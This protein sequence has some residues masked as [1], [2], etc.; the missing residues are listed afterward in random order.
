[1]GEEQSAVEQPHEARYVNYFNVGYNAFEVVVEFG[2]SYEGQAEPLFL[3]R[4]VTTPVYAKRLLLL[5]DD[6]LNRYEQ[7]FG[8]IPQGDTA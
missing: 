5:L 2:Q 7:Q 4:M 1:M 8:S 3:A 6:S